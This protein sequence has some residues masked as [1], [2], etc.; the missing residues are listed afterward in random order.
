MDFNDYIKTY[1]NLS[2]Q[3]GGWFSPMR[4]QAVR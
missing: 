1:E 2:K 4:L 3:V